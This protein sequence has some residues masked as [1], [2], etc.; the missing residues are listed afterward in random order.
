[1]LLTSVATGPNSSK[2]RVEIIVQLNTAASSSE[3]VV[4]SKGDITENGS[5]LTITGAD[6]CGAGTGLGPIYTMN[7]ATTTL[8]GSPTLSGTPPTPQYGTLNIDIQGLINSFR[9]SATSTITADQ[10]GAS[11]GSSTNYVNGLLGYRRSSKYP[12]SQTAECNRLRDSSGK[13]RL[14]ARRRVNWN[15]II[16]ATGSVTLNGGGGAGINVHG[17]VYAGTS[18]VTD[19]TI[20][21]SN[22]LGYDSCAVKKALSSQAFKVVSWKQGL[23][24]PPGAVYDPLRF[25]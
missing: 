18:T 15:G 20:N 19:V 2:A 24:I 23:L 22:T 3:A 1:M 10:N 5:S 12:G 4:Y 8:N 6:A 7:P 16:Y 17:Q 11:Y 13:G 14:D 21:G 9:P 25:M